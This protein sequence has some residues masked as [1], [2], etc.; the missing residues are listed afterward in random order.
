MILLLLDTFSQ[1][2]Q[3]QTFLRKLAKPKRSL[4]AGCLLPWDAHV[5]LLSRKPFSVHL[6][7]GIVIFSF[8]CWSDTRWDNKPCQMER[9][10][11]PSPIYRAPNP[12]SFL[13][14]SASKPQLWII[15]CWQKI[16][17]VRRGQ[18]TRW[19]RHFTPSPSPADSDQDQG[20]PSMSGEGE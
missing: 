6:W 20:G 16:Q 8:E 7:R 18:D 11:Q 15:C 9:S 17:P 5:S 19:I 4:P 10:R 13:S 2:W 1:D 12:I 14:L 3:I